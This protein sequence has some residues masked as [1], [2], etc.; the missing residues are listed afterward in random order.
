MIVLSSDHFSAFNF[1][2]LHSWPFPVFRMGIYAT[3]FHVF[4]L[5]GDTFSATLFSVSIVCYWAIAY[6]ID[7]FCVMHPNLTSLNFS[8]IPVLYVNCSFD[9][10]VHLFNMA[11]KYN[12]A[13][14]W[15]F[16]CHPKLAFWHTF[17]SYSHPL[18]CSVILDYSL[19]FLLLHKSSAN[20][21]T[22]SLQF[23]SSQN[24]ALPL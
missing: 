12:T 11:H 21:V 15:L 3:I 13:K 8:R 14:V 24:N 22:S 19:S 16:F 18:N 20:T 6:D 10:S 2:D 1:L 23:I 5:P 17:P 7:N 9:I 4:C